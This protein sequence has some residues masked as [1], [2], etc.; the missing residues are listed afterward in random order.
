[1]INFLVKIFVKNADDV[2]NPAVRAAYGR[3]AGVVG[4]VCNLLLC[5]AKLVV[6]VLSG[7][8]SITADAVNN[9]SDASSS[10]ITLVGFKLSAKP[11]DREHPYGHARIEYVAGLSV[12]VLILIIGVEIAK[13]GIGKILH[14]TSVEFTAW[15]VAVLVFSVAVKLW[16]MLF[17][18][19]VGRRIG[20]ATLRATAADSRND[21]I[22]TSVV[23]LAGV[24]E[25]IWGWRLDGYMGLCVAAFILWSGVGIVRDM[26][27]P[28][29]GAAPS[30]ELIE[31]ISKKIMSYEGVLGTHDLMVHDYGPGRCFGSVHVE[32]A[33]E[34]DVLKSHDIIDNIERDFLENDGIQ[35]VIHYDPIQTGSDAVGSLREWM[36]EEVKAIF[37]ALS[38]H[39]F[40][41]VQGPTHTNL[42]FDVMMPVDCPLS[43]RDILEQI[44]ARA[45]AKNPSYYTVVTLDSSFAPIYQ[46][47]S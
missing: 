45:F 12:A 14:P 33:S 23:L 26:L 4:I 21:A 22:T 38:L 24:I 42:I 29:I 18:N 32:M 34:E 13:S 9:L 44:Q 3:L 43:R 30:G 25:G 36:K 46:G 7:S 19:K 2:K 39:D 5:T 41:I 11:A 40:R 17:N 37:P 6:G 15:T 35:F 16:M 1:M 8:I 10:V 47:K 31:Y 28:L 20:S 27:N